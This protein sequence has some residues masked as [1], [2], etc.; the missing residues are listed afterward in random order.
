M[1]N[2][3]NAIIYE[4]NDFQLNNVPDVSVILVTYNQEKYVKQSIESILCQQ[5]ICK[6]EIVVHDDASTDNTIQV[7]LEVQKNYPHIIKIVSQKKNIYSRKIKILEHALTYARGK[8]VA[9][10][11][12]DDYWIDKFKIQKQFEILDKNP[13]I[14]ICGGKIL[15]EVDSGSS[16]LLQEYNPHLRVNKFNGTFTRIHALAG[17]PI[18]P[19]TW[20]FRN[21]KNFS[22]SNFE[23]YQ[24]LATGDDPFVLQILNFGKGYCLP[25]VVGVYRLNQGGVWSS[26]SFIINEFKM[27][28]YFLSSINYIPFHFKLI[29]ILNIAFSAS[30]ILVKTI[31]NFKIINSI[32]LKEIRQLNLSKNYLISILFIG[33]IFSPIF[34]FIGL[35][36]K[37]NKR[38]K[39]KLDLSYKKTD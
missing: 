4:Q 11:E 31:R 32:N 10:C 3:I 21:S 25:D 34:I 28:K 26:K 39:V 38:L 24:Q 37:L 27:I 13:D 6:Y 35:L 17:S 14:V 18:Q 33:I 7:L 5:T 29:Q 12:G 9:Y 20:M 1:F 15:I 30:H 2:E 23:L 19:L 36:K 8:Y 22:D 16:S